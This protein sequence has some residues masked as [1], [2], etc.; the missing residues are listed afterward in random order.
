MH[1]LRFPRTGVRAM[2]GKC[3][4]PMCRACTEL[5]AP[6]V[7]LTDVDGTVG[8]ERR[9]RLCGTQKWPLT[10]ANA[11]AP[12][13]NR[14]CDTRFRKPV[15]YPLSYEGGACMK[16]GRK[17]AADF[18]HPS[19]PS[20]LAL[21]GGGLAGAWCPH[22]R[23]GPGVPLWGVVLPIRS[24]GGWGAYAAEARACRCRCSWSASELTMRA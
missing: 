3:L 4:D 20:I 23:P 22:A 17:P 6:E 12:G 15:L 13:R 7:M 18:D 5:S 2:S 11:R 1:A 9:S 16:L 21:G 10:S 24:A 14:T 19:D 8:D